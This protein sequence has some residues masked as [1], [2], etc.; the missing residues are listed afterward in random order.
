MT[1]QPSNEQLREEFNRWADAGKGE[2]ME[3]EH[4]PI[5]KPVLERMNIALG[6]TDCRPFGEV[7]VEATGANGSIRPIA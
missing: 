3:H 7:G 6:E 1:E 5:T 4:W 2:S